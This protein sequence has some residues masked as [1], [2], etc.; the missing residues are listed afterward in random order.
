MLFHTED[1]SGGAAYKDSRVVSFKDGLVLED[2][3]IL[4]NVNEYEE[5]ADFQIQFIFPQLVIQQVQN[6][7]VARQLLPKGPGNFELIFNFFGY[8][9]DSA[10]MQMH[11]IK[12]ANLV[13]P[14]GLILMEDALATELVQSGTAGDSSALSVADMG[15]DVSDDENCS[16]V[17]SESPV[18]RLWR[19]YQ[20]LME[21]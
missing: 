14:A 1:T 12:E 3:S 5:Q 2:M 18:R 11:R 16:S 10:E 15:R 4:K 19:A 7:L 13:G 17:I 20:E 21:L 8:A 6:S 9:D